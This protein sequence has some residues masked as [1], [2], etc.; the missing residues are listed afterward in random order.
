[1]DHQSL[2]IIGISRSGRAAADLAVALGIPHVLITD[3]RPVEAIDSDDLCHLAQLGVT[4]E[5]G[6]HSERIET[7]APVAI[8]SP[9]I[10]PS[11]PV[12][13]RLQAA[14]VQLQSEVDFGFQASP[15]TV[16][17]IGITGTNGK[18][19]VTHLIHW[20]LDQQGYPAAVCGNIGVPVCD[21][22][23]Q[24]IQGTLPPNTLMVTELSSYQ[25][26]VNTA[27]KAEVAVFTN[28]QPDH[29]DWHG[30][31]DAYRAAKASLFTGPRSPRWSILNAQDAA[32]ADWAQASQGQTLGYSLSSA[33]VTQSVY[34]QSLHLTE[35]DDLV[36]QVN[37]QDGK[38]IASAIDFPLVGSHN[39]QNLLAAVGALWALECFK[40]LALTPAI[41]RFPG[42]PHR[43]E[44]VATVKG[45]TYINDSKATNP[46][47]SRLALEA[48]APRPLI[49]LAGGKEKGVSL[50][51]WAETATRLAG[52]V[53][54]Y[55]SG[56]DVLAQALHAAGHR[57][58]HQTDTLAQAFDRA[59]SQAQ[60]G[61]VVLLSPACASFD[62]FANFESR[63]DAFK[64]LV[65][66]LQAPCQEGATP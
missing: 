62:Q 49:L 15:P 46:E 48:L 8:L 21:V 4:I 66:L 50:T 27:F 57:C 16:R 63:G 17:W 11:A 38:S 28:L 59:V 26:A 2:T 3:H 64:A 39:K 5:T 6:G 20:L 9:G 43:I 32:S 45:V 36:L 31:M 53:V 65:T 55:G 22:V 7:H 42:V 34:D 12:V 61:Q 60:S 52:Q 47:A 30:S 13:Q 19:T 35:T 10:P 23:L 40:P 24:V 51:E 56:H 1:V 37:G 44:T 14:G 54:L 58:V 18:T 29:L 25:L 33:V 41:A